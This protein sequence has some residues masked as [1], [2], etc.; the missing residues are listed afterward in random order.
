MQSA[1][2]RGFNLES[3][4]ALAQLYIDH[5]F[6]SQNEADLFLTDIPVLGE[7]DEQEATVTDQMLADPDCDV[8]NL[9]RA[10]LAES[11]DNISSTFTPSQQRAFDWVQCQLDLGKPAQAAIVEP[12]GTGKSYL[13]KGLIQLQ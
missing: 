9:V 8:G 4:R 13:L 3:L 1:L 2:F 6:L 12:A 5:G 11:L 7:H 10:P